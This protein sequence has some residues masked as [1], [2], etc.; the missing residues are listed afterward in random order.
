[1][2]SAFPPPCSVSYPISLRQPCWICQSDTHSSLWMSR[3]P[4]ISITQLMGYVLV[5]VPFQR[6]VGGHLQPISLS[7]SIHMKLLHIPSPMRVYSVRQRSLS[8]LGCVHAGAAAPFTEGDK[9]AVVNLAPAP[10]FDAA[11]QEAVM[12]PPANASA[13]NVFFT[14]V[15]S[16]VDALVRP[17]LTPGV[18]QLS[19]WLVSL[20]SPMLLCA[21]RQ[22]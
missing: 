6:P 13:V 3:D 10:S 17:P 9:T 18:L 12:H 15:L 22:S 11:A 8:S 16:G 19:S 1:M 21:S 14:L 20:I 5:D 4:G 7:N 2:F